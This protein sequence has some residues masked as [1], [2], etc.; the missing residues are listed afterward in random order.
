MKKV[1]WDNRVKVIMVPTKEEYIEINI[2]GDLWCNSDEYREFKKE[3]GLE[4]KRIMREKRMTM[5][6]ATQ[7]IK[8]NDYY[9]SLNEA[10]LQ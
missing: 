1:S 10:S 2:H 3:Y 5:P 4:I 9:A 6:E 7:V 8:K